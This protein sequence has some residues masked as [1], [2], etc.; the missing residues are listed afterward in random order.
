MQHYGKNGKTHADY[1]KLNADGNSQD[2]NRQLVEMQKDMARIKD[3]ELLLDTEN[4]ILR[5]Q[6]FNTQNRKSATSNAAR[7]NDYQKLPSV[8]NTAVMTTTEPAQ[9]TAQGKYISPLELTEDSPHVAQN[10]T[11]TD[12]I[13]FDL[14]LDEAPVRLSPQK[15]KAESEAVGSVSPPQ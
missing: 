9:S 3:K 6:L 1:T 14:N 13:D 7:A 4:K 15:A 11:T 10:T 8:G 12:T 2:A 5:S